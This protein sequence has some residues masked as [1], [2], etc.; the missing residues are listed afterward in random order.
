[1]KFY[2]LQCQIAEFEFKLSSRRTNSNK[3]IEHLSH[4]GKQNIS[5]FQTVSPKHTIHSPKVTQ[6][7]K[8]RH[9]WF[10]SPARSIQE[11]KATMDSQEKE[12]ESMGGRTL[13][14][15]VAAAAATGRA[16]WG[17]SSS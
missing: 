12:S 6:N 10:T 1:M 16:R 9:P 11:F 17:R 3:R 5:K 7:L 14:S 13:R 2:L 15:C 4:G 8:H